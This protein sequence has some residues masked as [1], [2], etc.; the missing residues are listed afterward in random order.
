ML[1]PKGC[2]GF[3]EAAAELDVA[4]ECV[5]R[6]VY[7]ESTEDLRDYAGRLRSANQR[8]KAVREYL[9][10][11]RSLQTTLIST[12]RQRK[13]DIIQRPEPDQSAL[14]GLMAELAT[15]YEVDDVAYGLGIPGRVPPDYVKTLEDLNRYIRDLEEKLQSVGNDAQLANV[16]LQNMLQKQQQTLQMLSTI[17]KQLHDTA[18][19][20]IRKIGS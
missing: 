8:K 11:L 19:A 2:T 5:L 17:S 20:V 9:A 15:S 14:A 13:V 4:V 7:E 10:A 6:E 3:I 12:A 18:M 16:D 1:E